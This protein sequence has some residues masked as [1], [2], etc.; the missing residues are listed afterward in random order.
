MESSLSLDNFQKSGTRIWAINCQ[1]RKYFS[2][3]I[4]PQASETA[5]VQASVEWGGLRRDKAHR[6]KADNWSSTVLNIGILIWP[7]FLLKQFLKI[8]IFL[9]RLVL[10]LITFSYI[11]GFLPASQPIRLPLSL[12]LASRIVHP[13]LEHLGME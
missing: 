6:V 9:C 10:L 8:L 11:W 13:L 7:S 5:C 4:C 3:V 1:Q 12:Q 2:P